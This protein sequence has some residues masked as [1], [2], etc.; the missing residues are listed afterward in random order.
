MQYINFSNTWQ[1]YLFNGL[2]TSCACTVI[3]Y[4]STIHLINHARMFERLMYDIVDMQ[5]LRY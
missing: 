1:V 4:T 5:V 3:A 2:W